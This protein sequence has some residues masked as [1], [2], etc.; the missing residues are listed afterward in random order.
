M[1]SRIL[2]RSLLALLAVFAT[3]AHAQPF[4]TYLAVDGSDA[5]PCTLL[6]PCRLLPAALAAV[7][8]GGEIWLLD[9]ANYNTATVNVTKSVTILA[10]PGVVGSVVATGGPAINIAT[11]GVE[12]ALRNLVIVPLPGAGGTSGVVMTLGAALTVE[13]CLITNLSGSGISV[14]NPADVRVTDTTIRG[15]SGSAVVVRGGARAVITR[16]VASD[17]GSSGLR[18]EGDIAGT[19]TTMDVIASTVDTAFHGVSA[20]SDSATG[21]LKVSVSDSL[22]ARND[23]QGVS[24]Y[25]VAGAAVLVAVTNNRIASNGTVGVFAS[26]A[27]TKV[28]ASANTVSNNGT[29]I[30]NSGAIFESAGNNAVRNNFGSQTLGTITVVAME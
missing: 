16:V 19:T 2:S 24:V 25:S 14:S 22:I 28:W 21:A 30:G 5:N 29:G 13:N 15:N 27:G 9:A 4:R 11:A 18:A 26:G 23:N 3:S 6:Q 20:F 1:F 12:V 17:S 7:A 8:A 10:V